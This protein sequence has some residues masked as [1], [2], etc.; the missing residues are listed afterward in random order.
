ML[1]YETAIESSKSTDTILVGDDADLLV[2]LLYHAKI[3]G[4]ALYFRPEPLQN[5]KKR[6]ILNVRKTKEKLGSAICSRLLFVHAI[7]DMSRIYNIGKP[8][9]LS[10]IQGSELPKVADAFLF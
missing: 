10:K 5:S 7:C 3:K 1:I 6:R 2:L 4:E 9:A 8:V